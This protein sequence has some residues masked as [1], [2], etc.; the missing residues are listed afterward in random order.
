MI[1]I[2]AEMAQMEREIIVERV[3]DGLRAAVRRGKKLGPPT[4]ATP[5]IKDGIKKLHKEGM[6][7]KDIAAKY[8]FSPSTINRIIK[9]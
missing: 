8:G 7:Q 9:A 1:A 6:M 2:M 3:K 4:K 5:E